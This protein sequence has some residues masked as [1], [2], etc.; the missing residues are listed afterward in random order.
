MVYNCLVPADHVLCNLR[1][2]TVSFGAKV[3]Q[4]SEISKIVIQI[5]GARLHLIQDFENAH[6]IQDICTFHSGL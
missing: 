2:F 1:G 4:L 6:L 3:I 5:S